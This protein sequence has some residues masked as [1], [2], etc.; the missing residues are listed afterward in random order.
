M[1]RVL[2]AGKFDG[3]NLESSYQRAF[4]TL[5]CQ[6]SI[7]DFE[8]AVGR[9][10]RFGKLGRLVSTYLTVE[11]WIRKA[12]RDLVLQAL[13]FRSDLVIVIGQ[14]PIRAGA[15][16]QIKACGDVGLVCVWP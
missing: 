1:K 2:L 3:W 16:T 5:G 7:F 9:H 10:C 4:E 15:L 11:A 6:V 8:N 13:D 12:N 14:Q